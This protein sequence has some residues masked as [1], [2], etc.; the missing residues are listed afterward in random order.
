[1]CSKEAW[2]HFVFVPKQAPRPRRM[3]RAKD[4]TD[5]FTV[6]SR[7]VVE[8]K[9][10]VISRCSGWGGTKVSSSRS[11]ASITTVATAYCATAATAMGAAALTASGPHGLAG[12]ALL[13]MGMM[14]PPPPP[15]AMSM[16]GPTPD[17]VDMRAG[18]NGFMDLIF[19]G[20]DSSTFIWKISLLQILEYLGALLMGSSAGAP[21]LCSLYLL[22]AS[23][24]PSI[25][26][27][28]MWRL[29]TPIMLH[30][31]ALHIFFNMFFQLRIGFQMEKQFGR[32]KFCMLYLFGGLLG[33]LLSVAFDPM[34]LAVGA[35]TSGF[36]LLGVWLAE[37][38]LTWELLGTSRPRIFLWFAFMILSCVMMSTISPNVDFMGHLGGALG[39]WLMAVILAD[40][41]EEHQPAWYGKVKTMAKNCAALLICAALFKAIIMGPEF[42]VPSC[43]SILH[44][45]VLPF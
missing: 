41:Q 15:L 31:N 13:K 17:D 34:K 23:W 5:F 20:F 27:G 35:S 36:G 33:N 26:N 14:A 37:V 28:A 32:K 29:F 39:G 1:M 25:A 9:D 44:P 42:P 8:T 11:G 3:A 21:K 30:A 16:L 45:R 38:M 18:R 2:E 24:G 19:P 10:G 40:M 4:H 12:A 6:C 22:G 43:G 7:P